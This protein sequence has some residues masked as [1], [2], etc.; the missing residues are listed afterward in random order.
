MTKTQ[1]T[2]TH[3]ATCRRCHATLKSARSVARGIGPVC[4][5]N[6]RRERAAA[7]LTRGFKGAESARTKA[8]ALIADRAL[9]PTRHEGQYLAASSDGTQTYLV[10]TIER[11]CTC[12]GHQR[13]GRCCHLV[14]ADVLEMATRRTQLALAA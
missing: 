2:A 6:E 8:L 5:R 1:T 14:A 13:V 10:D 11:S 7:V 4:E 3:T 9:V 12:K